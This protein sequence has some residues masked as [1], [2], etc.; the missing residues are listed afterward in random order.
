MVEAIRDQW[1][2]VVAIVVLVGLGV[3]LWTTRSKAS[4]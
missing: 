3:W 4:R 1:M 2:I